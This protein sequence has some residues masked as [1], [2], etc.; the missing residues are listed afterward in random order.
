LVE[1]L[2]IKRQ[3]KNKGAARM[4]TRELAKRQEQAVT[5]VIGQDPFVFSPQLVSELRLLPLAGLIMVVANWLRPALPAGSG[6]RPVTYRDESIL[7]AILVM[8][9]WQ[10]SPEK[11]VRLMKRWSE[12]AAACDFMPG[13]VISASQLRR[14]RDNLGIG[15][16]FVTFVV[17]V[18]ILIRRGII[19][20]RDWVIDSTI[21]DAFS[22]K[23]T[24]AAW[25]FSQRF[26]YKVHMLICRDSLLPIMFLVSPAN[27]NDAPWAPRLM[28]LAHHLFA[29]PV[30][31][32]RA[33]AAYYTKVVVGFILD[34][35]KAVPKVVHNPRKAGKKALATLEWV[36]HYRR[37][38]G[39][40]GYIERFF[41]LLKHYYRL[42]QLRRMGL[43]AAYRHAGE[44]CFAVLLT[45]WLADYL[46]RP[47]L[48]HA[49]SR[50]LAPC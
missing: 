31:V 33:D 2:L 28:A 27:A 13:E 43:W 10:L 34:V 5:K 4:L 7:V 39:K 1:L 36:A 41:A 8:S 35:L 15:V 18:A 12:L 14:R 17:L 44:V 24:G 38:R 25:S 30:E 23:D 9:L 49:R 42:N 46:E 16:Y 3:T 50:L 32:V 47:D 21:I 48:I 45:A 37:D 11:M 29:L 40:R 26:G 19:W 6:G 20:G 22:K